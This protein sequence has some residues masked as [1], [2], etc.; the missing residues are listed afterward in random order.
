[1]E[2]ELRRELQHD[3]AAAAVVATAAAALLVVDGDRR[4]AA[5]V[6]APPPPPPT[7]TAKNEG[8]RIAHGAHR[9]RARVLRVEAEY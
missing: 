4:R 6:V 3:F 1:M 8:R 7:R 5:V 9:V 2:D